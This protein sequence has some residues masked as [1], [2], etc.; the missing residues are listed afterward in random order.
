VLPNL[1]KVILEASISVLLN[2]RFFSTSS[3]RRAHVC[4]RRE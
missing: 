2:L 1:Y 3:S 4:H